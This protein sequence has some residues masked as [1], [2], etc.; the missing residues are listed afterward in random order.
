MSSLP[1]QNI[2]NPK[3]RLNEQFAK[4]ARTL[5]HAHRLELIEQLA[6]GERSVEALAGKLALSFANTSQHLQQMRR[7]GLVTTRRDGKR[8]F[9]SLNDGPVLE[10]VAALQRL[11]EATLAEVREVV[12]SYFTQKDSMEPVSRGELA[13][14][15]RAGSVTLLDLRPEDEF[16]LGHVPGALNIPLGQLE[17]RLAELPGD[18]E[19]I[20]YCR[21]PYCI[22]SFEAV[23]LLRSRGLAVRRLEDGFPEWREA[24]MPVAVGQA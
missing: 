17:T 20:A 8:I 11:A 4:L 22:L 24:D 21:G 14:R 15:L 23:A 10:A 5:G 2:A 18:R 13:A 19:I 1:P 3:K 7:A 12:G 16:V 6:Q 9:Y